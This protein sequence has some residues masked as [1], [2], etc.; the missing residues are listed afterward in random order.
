MV[1]E[2]GA[3]VIPFIQTQYTHYDALGRVYLSQLSDN[4][5]VGY[6]YNARGF[7]ISEHGLRYNDET[8]QV[9]TTLLKTINSVNFRGQ[10]TK[11]TYLRQSSLNV[12]L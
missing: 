1:F 2:W 6:K 11:E 7:K 4:Y 5:A 12:W 10:V 9:D 8:K 3:L